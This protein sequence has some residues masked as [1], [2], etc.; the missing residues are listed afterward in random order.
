M[1]AEPSLLRVACR[2]PWAW[3]ALAALTALVLAGCGGQETRTPGIPPDT[4]SIFYTCDTR[5]HIE[6]CGCAS[7]QAGGIARRMTFLHEQAGGAH[8]LVDAGDVTAGPRNWEVFEM[9]YILKGYAAMGYHAVNAG[10][11]EASLGA[12]RLLELGERYP[13]FV[14]ANVLDADGDPLF[15]PYR[16]VDFDRGFRV[17]ILGV[18]DDRIDPEDRGA[19]PKKNC[20][21]PYPI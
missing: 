8:L 16:F 19:N 14:S 15:P 1:W 21:N 5:G 2:A 7:G 18:M 3:P 17:G 12:E 20:K 10:H 4:L 13:F 6:P 11:R 9:E